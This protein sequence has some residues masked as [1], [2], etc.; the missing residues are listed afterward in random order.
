MPSITPLRACL[1]ALSVAA[2][3]ATS[4]CSVFHRRDGSLRFL[5]R[6][7]NVDYT[8]ARENRPLDVPPD[9][10]TPATDPTMQVPAVGGAAQANVAGGPAFNL[11]DTPAS[12]WERLGK[13]LD[14]IDGVTVAQRSQ[15]LGSF[16]VQYKGA[17]VLLRVS[18]NGASSRIDAVGND[19][20]PMRSPE[21]VELLGLLRDR[22]G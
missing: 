3:L 7:H 18:P 21:A 20:Q 11:S 9:L 16:G 22:L 19:G 1:A 2:L 13:A 14:H 15:L 10:D 6:A 8:R 5:P 12:S 17:S 4:G